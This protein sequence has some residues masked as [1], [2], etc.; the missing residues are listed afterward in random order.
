MSAD[1]PHDHGEV[2]RKSG[3][4]SWAWLFPLIAL[5]AAGW[6]YWQHVTSMGPEIRIRFKEAPGIEAGKTPL[7]F[8]GLVAGRVVRVNLTGDLSEAIVHV[9]LEKFAADL[10]VETTTFWIER[11]EISLQGASGL[12]SLIQGNSIRA[13]KGTGP[14]ATHFQGLES[15]PVLSTEDEPFNLRLVSEQTQSLDRGAPVTFRGVRVG[16]V[17]EQS[18]TPDGSPFIDISVDRDKHDLLKISSRFWTVPASSVTLGPGGIK[19]VVPGL[20]TLIQGAVAFDDFGVPGGPLG[21]GAVMQL[22]ASE[23]L[24]RACSPQIDI[25]FTSGRGLRAGQTR[26]TYLGVAVGIVTEI[27]PL[28]GAVHVTARFNR[29]FDFLRL[30]GSQF[31]II[32]PQIT[33]KGVS[34]LETILTGPVIECTPGRGSEF[35]SEFVG[36]VPSGKEEVVEQSEAGR[37]FRLVSSGTGTREGAPVLYRDM[38]VGVVLEKILSKDGSNIELIVGIQREYAHLVRKN[39]VFW[40]QRGLRGSIGFFSIRLQTANP[41]PLTG[42]GAIT[43]ASPDEAGPE[44]PANTRFPLYDKPQREWKKWKDPAFR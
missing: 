2:V 36:N 23:E 10:A 35:R 6:M 26:M 37:K 34:G 28:D 14:P 24:A 15:S 30:A 11:P 29:G 43:F 27:Q 31:T 42:S 5:G 40:E 17:R 44:A 32:E 41:M 4:L 33:L 21:E 9:R 12:T 20:D 16:R 1:T 22:L 25:S 18:L 38:Q 19:L 13:L 39:T 8:R 3:G 7:H